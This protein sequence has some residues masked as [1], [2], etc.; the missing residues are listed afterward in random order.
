MTTQTIHDGD[1]DIGTAHSFSARS[2]NRTTDDRGDV[3]C[4]ATDVYHR[5]GFFIIDWHTRADSRCLSFFDHIHATDARFFSGGEQSALFDLGDFG[6]YAHD[7]AAAE[8]RNTAACFPDEVVQH[9]ARSFEVRHHTI[10]ERSNNGDVARFAALHLVSFVAA[11]DDFTL[12][13]IE[14]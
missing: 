5:R 12:A 11:A 6:E 14:G 13:F 3:C 7:R 8:V 2:D 9:R 4:T 1:V 10:D